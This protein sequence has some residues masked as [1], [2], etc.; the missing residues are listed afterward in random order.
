MLRKVIGE[1]KSNRSIW[2]AFTASA[3]IHL[4][5]LVGLSLRLSNPT[6]SLQEQVISVDLLEIARP[7]KERKS[8]QIRGQSKKVN[9]NHLLIKEPKKTPEFRPGPSPTPEQ[10]PPLDSPRTPGTPSP[11]P[12]RDDL[13]ID[14]PPTPLDGPERAETKREN[15]ALVPT[16]GSGV[17]ENKGTSRGEDNNTP[18]SGTWKKG[19]REARPLQT[20]RASYPLMALRM[21][22]EAD[23]ELKIQ[24]DTE[25]KVIRAEIIKS[26][27]MGFDKEAL[28][29]VRRF[30]FKPAQKDGKDI[31]SEL[32]YIYRF[33]LE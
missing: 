18:G 21:G 15:T 6:V 20:V 2:M 25:G 10:P 23:V 28:K 4:F 19:F 3:A 29:A 7:A 12:V 14:F 17:S 30:R 16:P 11:V 26:A 9:P 33:R 31:A 27:G 5:L 8:S 1:P 24:V 13:N 32:T 22:L